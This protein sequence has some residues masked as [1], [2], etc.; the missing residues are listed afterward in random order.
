MDTPHQTPENVEITPEMIEA[1]VAALAYFD[2]YFELDSEG[3]E[4]IYLA[5]E[6]ARQKAQGSCEALGSVPPD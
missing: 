5:M 2:P 3:V 6:S 4:K 1:G